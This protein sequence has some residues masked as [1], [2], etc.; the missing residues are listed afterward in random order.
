METVNE[1][2]EA[3][4][5]KS[6]TATLDELR[7]EGRKQVRLIRAEHIAAMVSEAVH[8][9]IEESGLIDPAEHERLVEKSRVEFRAIL[10]QRQAEAERAQEIESQLQQR[11]QE[12]GEAHQRGEALSRSLIEARAELERAREGGQQLRGELDAVR[13]SLA[14]VEALVARAMALAEARGSEL[15]DL[16]ADLQR[17]RAAEAAVRGELAALEQEVAAARTTAPAPAAS[18][19]PTELMMSLFQELAML[20]ANMLAQRPQAPAPAAPAAAAA[21]GVDLAAVLD[22]LTSSLNDRLETFGRK[23]GISSATEGAAV[24]F[25]GMFK[26]TGKELESNMGSIEVKQKA[27]GGIAANLARLKKLKGGG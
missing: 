3:L 6:R 5:A 11:E 23:M 18:A 7:N 19:M 10:Q 4:S 9:A 21:P 8:S 25:S 24:D 12:L 20:K 1:I 14:G 2:K 17:A 15:D 16:R 13:G 27:G 22:K 26:D